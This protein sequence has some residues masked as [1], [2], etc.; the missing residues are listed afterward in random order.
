M[1]YETQAGLEQLWE[2]QCRLGVRWTYLH[3]RQSLL[4]LAVGSISTYVEVGTNKVDV[5]FMISMGSIM[6]ASGCGCD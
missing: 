4:R 3:A 2:T 5:F 6:M 1:A